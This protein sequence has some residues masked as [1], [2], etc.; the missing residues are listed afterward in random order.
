MISVHGKD[1]GKAVWISRLAFAPALGRPAGTS[2]ARE[3][4]DRG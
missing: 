2:L 4:K 3:C 1:N